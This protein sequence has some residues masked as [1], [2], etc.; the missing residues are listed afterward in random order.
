MAPLPWYDFRRIEK[1][2]QTSTNYWHVEI[3]LVEA[4]QVDRQLTTWLKAAYELAGP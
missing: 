2:H 4:A 1:R 3:R